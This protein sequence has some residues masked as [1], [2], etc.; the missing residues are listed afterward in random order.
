MASDNFRR[1]L[2]LFSIG[3]SRVAFGYQFQTVGSIGPELIVRFG[4]DYTA[5]GALVG[6]YMLLGVFGA[7]PIGLLGRRFGEHLVVGIGLSLMAVGS[8]VCT[9]IGGL[10]GATR[11]IFLG[12]CVSGVGAVAM[13]VLGRLIGWA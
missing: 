13:I 12:R 2:I 4:I 1:W 11:A 5:L 10:F 3:L 9:D 6:A 7:L 8:L